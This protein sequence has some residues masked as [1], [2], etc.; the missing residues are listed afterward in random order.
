MPSYYLLKVSKS[1]GKIS[2]TIILLPFPSSSDWSSSTGH[3]LISAKLSNSKFSAQASTEDVNHINI[4][5]PIMCQVL[6]SFSFKI[7]KQASTEEEY[8]RDIKPIVM[9]TVCYIVGAVLFNENDE[10]DYSYL[11]VFSLLEKSTFDKQIS[12]LAVLFNDKKE[13]E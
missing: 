13:V 3:E 9:E 6:A 4:H 7:N 2:L 11:L 10:V 8:R 12:K 1:S 5:K